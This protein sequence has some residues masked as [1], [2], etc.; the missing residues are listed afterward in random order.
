ME[1][2]SDNTEHF[3][4]LPTVPFPVVFLFLKIDILRNLT[5]KRTHFYRKKN[6]EFSI[7]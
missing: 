6:P 1:K 4:F 5:H 3:L 7:K 2:K